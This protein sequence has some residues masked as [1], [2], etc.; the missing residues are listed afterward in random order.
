MNK[1]RKISGQFVP[2]RVEVLGSPAFACT[3]DQVPD[4]MAAAIQRRDLAAWAAGEGIVTSH[5]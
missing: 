3:P 4:L 1:R 5:A 2:R